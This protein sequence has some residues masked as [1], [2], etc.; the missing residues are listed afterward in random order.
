MAEYY[1]DGAVVK[2]CEGHKY[3]LKRTDS[4]WR[5]IARN[6]KEYVLIDYY[7]CEKCLH[8][9]QKKKQQQVFISSDGNEDRIEDWAKTITYHA[10]DAV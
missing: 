6:E 4:Y 5:Y 9:H 10:K 8:E 3:V 2:I 1:N 7:F